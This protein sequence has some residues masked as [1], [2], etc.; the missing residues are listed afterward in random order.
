VCRKKVSP[1]YV[2]ELPTHKLP[3]L[4]GKSQATME[5]WTFWLKADVVFAKRRA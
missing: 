4:A 5:L 3:A 1:G 2:K